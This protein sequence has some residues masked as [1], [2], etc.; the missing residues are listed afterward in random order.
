MNE[1]T[2]KLAHGSGGVLTRR[3]IQET[4]LRY[5]PSPL[6]APLSDSATLTVHGGRVAFTTDSYV[7]EPIFFPGGDIGRLAVCG[8]V[9]D[10]AVVGALPRFVSCSL[11]LEEGFPEGDLEA[12]LASMRE[13]AAECGVEVVTGDTKVVP[14]GKADRLFVN[15]AGIGLL[16]PGQRT[17][18]GPM[19]AGDAVVVSGPLGD[20][21]AAVL[22]RREGLGLQSSVLSDCAPVT[23][24][25]QAV[26]RTA[27]RVPFMRDVTRGGLAT[28][29]NEA[30]SGSPVGILLD[31][32]DVPIRAEVR[33]ICELL[34][35]D[36]LYLA[37]EGR[38]ATIVEAAGADRVVEAVRKVRG[39]EE[40]CIVGHACRDYAGQLVGQTPFGTRRLIQMLSG[41][42]LPRI[43]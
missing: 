39:G 20:H 38:V 11:I 37:C 31:E 22:A 25:A 43:C 19:Q 32:Q 3:L 2:I 18:G 29:L 8:T 27:E 34:G 17:P 30:V 6:L 14:H 15:T 1:R 4:L 23:A 16:E 21:G 7:V 12:V 28:I 13:A 42:Q 10:L 40:C 5:F 35:L 36:P 41:E 24:I 26:L 9:N 33:S